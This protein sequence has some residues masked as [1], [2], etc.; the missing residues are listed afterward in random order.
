MWVLVVVAVVSFLALAWNRWVVPDN[1]ER[2]AAF[3]AA[4]ADAERLH[5]AGVLDEAR[6]AYVRIA[7]VEPSPACA[8][9]RWA[10]QADDWASAAAAERGAVYFRAA[11]LKRGKSLADSPEV[12]FARARNAYINALSLDP[13]A[14][15][16]RR[17]LATLVAVMSVPSR[18]DDANARCAFADRLR[19]ARLFDVARIAY[20]QALR[21]GLTNSCVRYGVRVLRQ[22]RASAEGIVR[23]ARALDDDGREDEARAHYVAALAWDPMAPGARGAL[24]ATDAPDPRDGTT[25]GHLRDMAGSVGVTVGDTGTAAAWVKDNVEAFALGVVGVLIALPVLMWILYGLTVTP[26]GRRLVGLVHLPRFARKQLTVDPFTPADKAGTSQALFMYW[27]GQP[28]ADPK[29]VAEETFNDS[30]EADAVTDLWR[31]PAA[32]ASEDLNALF[33][34]TAASG[35]VAAALRLAQRVSPARE[36]RFSGEL[37]DGSGYGPGLRVIA[38][39]RFHTPPDRIWWAGDLPSSPVEPEAEAEARHALAIVAATWAHGQFGD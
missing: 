16:A 22:E 37:L 5:G 31:A 25:S 12:A 38:T 11:Q 23:R 4:C 34:G 6:R 33:A 19:I 20:A 29:A 21:S 26:R 8:S 39:R 18:A 3:A 1:D 35:P 30:N 24:G 13:Y 7:A 14:R 9:G 27:L 28:L 2:D 15:D 32:P 36:V 17:E 10:V